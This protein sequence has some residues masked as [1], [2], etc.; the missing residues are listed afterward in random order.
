MSTEDSSL[1]SS[2]G[3]QEDGEAEDVRHVGC[4]RPV[5][6]LAIQFVQYRRPQRPDNVGMKQYSSHRDPARGIR[7]RECRG[8]IRTGRSK[9]ILEVECSRTSTSGLLAKSGRSTG[10]EMSR[11]PADWTRGITTMGS[12][13]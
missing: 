11:V 6:P 8:R 3:G 12:R 9:P 1:K 2:H 5:R 4:Q 13:S 10:E 7:T